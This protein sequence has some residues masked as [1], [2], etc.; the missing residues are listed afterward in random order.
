ML[1]A[2]IVLR[3]NLSVVL[4]R[5]TLFHHTRLNEKCQSNYETIFLFSHNFQSLL[6]QPILS[7]LDNIPSVYLNLINHQF[8]YYYSFWNPLSQLIIL[9]FNQQITSS[10]V[11]CTHTAPNNT[12]KDTAPSTTI[13]TVWSH[14]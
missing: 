7:Q 9:H 11:T 2:L 14:F 3:H 1:K 10:N 8:I 4:P 5:N 6:N 12:A 13:I